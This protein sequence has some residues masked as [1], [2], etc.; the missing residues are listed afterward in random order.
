MPQFLLNL[1]LDW[2][3]SAIFVGTFFEGPVVGL[4]AGLF[5][6]VGYLNFFA[7]YVAHVLGDFVADFVYYSIGYFGGEKFLPR[8][9][10]F[11]NFS[12]D[13]VERARIK[14]HQNGKKIVILG[15]L[16]HVIGMPILVA[17]GLARYP[18]ARFAVFNLVATLIKSAAIL[19]LGYYFGSFWQKI[20]NVF[21]D[22]T[23]IAWAVV[24]IPTAYLIFKRL[25][26]KRE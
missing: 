16:T 23:L 22:I 17:A 3:Y 15:K 5:A 7:A 9:A 13:E 21:W 4:L 19:A 26:T 24:V 11:L 14:F 8:A 2:K 12:V 1:I 18:A 20:N 6:R 25:R 10:K